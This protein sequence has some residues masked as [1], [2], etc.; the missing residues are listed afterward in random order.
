M[1]HTDPLAGHYF[2]EQNFGPGTVLASR[3][4]I[5]TPVE[6]NDL[7]LLVNAYDSLE[8]ARG[9][10]PDT[11]IKIIDER[12]ITDDLISDRFLSGLFCLAKLKHQNLERIHLDPTAFDVIKGGGGPLLLR[13]DI[14]EGRS[15]RAVLTEYDG[16]I[17]SP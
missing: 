12:F 1:L 13:S 6:F 8:A 10:C 5:S 4:R 11:R 17:I 16:K 3:Y 14:G 2:Y 9:E 15:L 7:G